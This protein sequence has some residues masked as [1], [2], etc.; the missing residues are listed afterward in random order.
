MEVDNEAAPTEEEL[1]KWTT[2]TD[3]LDQALPMPI[4]EAGERDFFQAH[5]ELGVALEMKLKKH[6]P[7]TPTKPYWEHIYTI[8]ERIMN[9]E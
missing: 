3:L 1:K 9:Q 4:P 6:F 5:Q 2:L 8:L 7:D